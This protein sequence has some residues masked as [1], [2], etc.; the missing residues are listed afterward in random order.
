MQIISKT[1]TSN[2]I[3]EE[4]ASYAEF[5]ALCSPEVCLYFE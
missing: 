2:Y 1:E 3:K 5:K 4:A